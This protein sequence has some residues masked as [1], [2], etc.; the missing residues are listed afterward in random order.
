[1]LR[2]IIKQSRNNNN[3]MPKMISRSGNKQHEHDLFIKK[4]R[5]LYLSQL[6][7]LNVEPYSKSDLRQLV[8]EKT[9]NLN[10]LCIASGRQNNYSVITQII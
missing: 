2:F 9:N 10:I 6:K 5:R 4:R 3:F 1:M 8:M 7:F